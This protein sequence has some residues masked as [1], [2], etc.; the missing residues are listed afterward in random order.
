MAKLYHKVGKSS[1]GSDSPFCIYYI[2]RN[3]LN[4]VKK[5]RRCFHRTAYLFSL[6]SRVIRMMQADDKRVRKAYWQAI[7]DHQKGVTGKAILE[8]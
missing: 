7:K 8:D 3:R 6:V 1:G 4:Y 2:T 5:Y